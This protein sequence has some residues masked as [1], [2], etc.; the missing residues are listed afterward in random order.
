MEEAVKNIGRPRT[1]RE[2]QNKTTQNHVTTWNTIRYHLAL[3][4]C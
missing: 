4:R 1:T 3:S 2:A